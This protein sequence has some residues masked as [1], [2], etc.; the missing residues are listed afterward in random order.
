LPYQATDSSIYSK[1]DVTLE[2]G[3]YF[4]NKLVV[5]KRLED[6]WTR[7]YSG[8]TDATGKV[9]CQLP[10]GSYYVEVNKAL[11]TTSIVVTQ[12]ASFNVG[13]A[14]G[15]VH[16]QYPIEPWYVGKH[17]KVY[18][19]GES[20]LLYD[21]TIPETG[22]IPDFALPVDAVNS[23]KYYV[24]NTDGTTFDAGTILVPNTSDITLDQHQTKQDVT[25]NLGADTY[26]SNKEFT[27]A[28]SSNTN[29]IYVSTTSSATGTYS[30]Q[31]PSGTYYLA[32]KSG[33]LFYTF[34]VKAVAKVVDLSAR[35]NVNLCPGK[36]VAGAKMNVYLASPKTLLGTVTLDADGKGVFPGV[37]NGRYYHNVYKVN[38]TDTTILLKKFTFVIEGADFTIGDANNVNQPYYL[39]YKVYYDIASGQPEIT[40]GVNPTTDFTAGSLKNVKWENLPIDTIYTLKD[41]TWNIDHTTYVVNYDSTKISEIKYFNWQIQYYFNGVNRPATQNNAYVRGDQF[42]FR[43]APKKKLTFVTPILN[44][45]RYNVYMSNRWKGAVGAPTVDTTYMDGKP[46]YVADGKARSFYDWGDA[47]TYR[48]F[49]DVAYQQGL[50]LGEALVTKTGT[51]ELSLYSIAGSTGA[52]GQTSQVWGGM[53]YFIPVDQDSVGINVTYYPRMDYTGRIYYKNASEGSTAI[54]T[55]MGIDGV[56]RPKYFQQ[57]ADPSILKNTEVDFTKKLTINGGIYS[58]NDVLTTIS[59][60][61][62]WTTK[63]ANADTFGVATVALNPKNEAYSWAMDVEGVKGKAVVSD[64]NTITIPLSISTSI[65]SNQSVTP[66]IDDETVGTY[67]FNSTVKTQSLPFYYPITG[68][69]FYSKNG[70]IMKATGDTMK[71]VKTDALNG[72]AP[73]YTTDLPIL[74]YVLTSRYSGNGTRLQ[75]ST[76]TV[77][78]VKGVK[79]VAGG[80]YPNPARETMNLK[81][82]DNAG[83]AC[84]QIY[85]QLGQIVRHGS[86][87]GTEYSASLNGVSKGLYIVKVNVNGMNWNTK[88]IVE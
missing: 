36:T 43:L 29:A 6:K 15:T 59:P 71:I 16:A 8:T 22:I 74:S 64:N 40:W 3:L 35:Y 14:T 56:N 51:H 24:K 70:E 60:L 37:T 84:F 78:S 86:F 7:L 75:E 48:Q 54:Q 68:V 81:L 27:I 18:N 44:P 49:I 63:A 23:Y 2:A 39:P 85:N 80:I 10:A 73:T 26:G 41:T 67:A 87:T 72:I 45:G 79:S 46:L 21:Y 12:N 52:I 61:D 66:S 20:V 53:I 69:V 28:R 34:E 42:N 13:V 33:M 55:S 17:F 58:K 76:G 38:G 5:V 9:S 47:T 31:L 19:P 32:T 25:I 82:N 30:T 11:Y 83:I 62:N 57:F 65:V 88:L 50:H 1:F 4:A 77:V